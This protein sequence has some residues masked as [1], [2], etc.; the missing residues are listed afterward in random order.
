M[1]LSEYKG[2]RGYASL[3]RR[4]REMHESVL[5]VED[6][7]SWTRPT[8]KAIRDFIYS[9][10]EA[11]SLEISSI[12]CRKNGCE[13]QVLAALNDIARGSPPQTGWQLIVR[14][15]KGSA[16]GKSLEFEQDLMGSAADRSVYITVLRRVPA[17]EP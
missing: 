8:E 1:L 13:I 15:L 2:K 9:Q 4:L 17:T 10:P 11:G 5:A 7:P 3:H 6:E 14:R 16:L 12:A